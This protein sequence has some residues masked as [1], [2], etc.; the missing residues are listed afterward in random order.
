MTLYEEI[1]QVLKNRAEAK[2]EYWN[3][4]FL[5]EVNG[6]LEEYGHIEDEVVDKW[7]KDMWGC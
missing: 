6:L 5:S 7:I 1:M 4:Y 3:P 2:H